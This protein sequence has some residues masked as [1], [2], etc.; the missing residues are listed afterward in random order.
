VAA[1]VWL[2]GRTR[3]VTLTALLAANECVPQP[4]VGGLNGSDHD[5]EDELASR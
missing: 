1:T 2:P 4:F 5:E 3:N